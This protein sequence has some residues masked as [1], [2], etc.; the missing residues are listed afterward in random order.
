MTWKC[1]S[2]TSCPICI[3]GIKGKLI[4]FATL[5]AGQS[6]MIHIIEQCHLRKPRSKSK[7][8]GKDTYE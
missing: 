8:N 7:D 6:E 3:Y 4:G 1:H 5:K 2:Q